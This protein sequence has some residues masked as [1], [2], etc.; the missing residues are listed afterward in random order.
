MLQS[1]HLGRLR[2]CYVP[3]A[4]IKSFASAA[5]LE[6]FANPI[7]LDFQVVLKSAASAAS[8]PGQGAP[9][10]CPEPSPASRAAIR[11][12]P[13]LASMAAL[14]T[15]RRKRQKGKNQHIFEFFFD[16]GLPCPL[17]ACPAAR[18]PVRPSPSSPERHPIA[19]LQ[20]SSA[21]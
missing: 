18:P 21:T 11:H 14:I 16:Q 9:G 2:M 1:D 19:L 5:S 13:E 4:V 3:E 7:K 17:A 20:G 8:N 12:P 6:G 10:E 15:G